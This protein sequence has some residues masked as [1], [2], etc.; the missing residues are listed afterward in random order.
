MSKSLHSIEVQPD[1]FGTVRVDVFWTEGGRLM[2]DQYP[3]VD[4]HVAEDIVEAV[5]AHEAERIAG[6]PDEG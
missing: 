1:L 3:C 2:V 4:P 6:P 5:L